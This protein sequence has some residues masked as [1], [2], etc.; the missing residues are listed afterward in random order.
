MNAVV[1]ESGDDSG[2]PRLAAS[3][4]ALKPRIG[5]ARRVQMARSLDELRDRCGLTRRAGV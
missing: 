4:A 3:A 2:M 5:C 1:D